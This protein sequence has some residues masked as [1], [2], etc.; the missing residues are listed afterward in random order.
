MSLPAFV[1]PCHVKRDIALRVVLVLLAVVALSVAAATL[2]TATTSGG[3]SRVGSGPNTESGFGNDD[4]SG[5]DVGNTGEMGGA[6]LIALPCYPVLASQR[7]VTGIV[8]VFALLGAGVYWRTRSTV[9]SVAF[10]AGAGIPVV[11]LH[12]FLTGC[13]TP[14]RQTESSLLPIPKNG[15]S[16]LPGA[17]GATGVS[18]AGEVLSAPSVLL[19][20][21]LLVA[22]VGS[23]LTLFVSTGDSETETPETS[24]DPDETTSDV[25]AVGRVAGVAADR[26][27]ADADVENEVFRA[28]TEMTRHLDVSHPESQTPGEFA[29]AAVDAG[30]ARDDV[31]ELTDLFEAVRYGG[32]DATAEREER[33]LAALR[34]IESTYAGEDSAHPTEEGS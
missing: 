27:E 31:A 22:V 8:V 18:Q 33:A 20:V 26:I 9:L 23:A 25:A 32:A 34:R 7:V 5:G 24:A 19:G 2:D 10:V 21:V 29:A 13:V 11:V 4:E 1:V 6:A 3:G 14:Q 16:V 15:S 17:S 30:M 12:A 28:W